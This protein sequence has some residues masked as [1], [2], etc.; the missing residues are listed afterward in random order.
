MATHSS[1]LVWRIPGTEEPSGLP[2]MGVTQSQTQL[3]TWQQ[4]QPVAKNL[5]ANSGDNRFDPWSGKIP[6]AM[7]QLSSWWWW[8]WWWF[9]SKSSPTLETAWTVACQA[10]LSMGFSRQEYWS[11]LPFPS[12]GDFPNPGIEPWSPALQADSLLTE[13]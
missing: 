2:S 3:K 6:S 10:P 11:G 13:L 4:Q 1:V 7:E 9:S 5:P 8:W 12:P